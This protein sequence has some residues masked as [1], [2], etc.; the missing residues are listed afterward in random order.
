MYIA[1]SLFFM[2]KRL[3]PQYL[4]KALRQAGLAALFSFGFVA[5][6]SA[7]IDYR[8]TKVDYDVPGASLNEARVQMYEVTPI[9]VGAKRFGGHTAS[10]WSW[11]LTYKTSGDL[12]AVDTVKIDLNV[13]ITL[14][15]WPERLY[16]TR[17]ERVEWDR[18]LRSLTRHENEHVEIIETGVQ[19]LK[20]K[21]QG[22]P[23]AKTCEA[24]TR[25]AKAAALSTERQIERANT[26][27]D[28]DTRHGAEDGAQIMADIGG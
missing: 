7:E 16:A 5:S 17:A 21:L 6:A 18:F 20:A 2:E 11:K 19:A 8:T 10:D 27:L 14:P 28:A 13:T 26:N 3:A 15:T 22:L 25:S 9:R 12:C 24:L 4:M 1:G 23:P